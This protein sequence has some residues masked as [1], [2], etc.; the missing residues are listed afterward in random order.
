MS[1]YRPEINDDVFSD[2]LD[3]VQEPFMYRVLLHNDDYTSMEFVVEVLQFVFNK[4]IE[5]STRIMLKVHNEGIGLCG[6]YTYEIAE[7][8]VNMVKT[9]AIEREFPLKCTMERD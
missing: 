9:L 7:T 3:E 8:K 1:D 4:S 6:I 5:D 2:A